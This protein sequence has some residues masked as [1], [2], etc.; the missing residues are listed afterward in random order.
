MLLC[1][2]IIIF[3]GEVSRF[4][5]VEIQR[6][7]WQRPITVSISVW[8]VI[9]QRIWERLIAYLHSLKNRF[10]QEDVANAGYYRRHRNLQS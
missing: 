5:Y 6:E 7:C 9:L 10:K 8:K 3:S 4:Q 1:W 2:M